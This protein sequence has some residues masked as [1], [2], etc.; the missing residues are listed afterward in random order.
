VAE[1]VRI[2]VEE[3]GVKALQELLEVAVELK[4]SGVLGWLKTLAEN[5]EK[6]IELAA[7]DYPLFRLLALLQAAAGGAAR[8]EPGEFAEARRNTEETIHCLFSGLR[9]ADP[10]KAPKVGML[11]L[12]SALRDPAVQK[13][14]GL[15]LEIAR[16]LGECAEAK[17]KK[18]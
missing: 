11:G 6:I 2:D 18:S 10:A 4:K 16:G 7:S 1:K 9:R 12:T 14:L 17:S 15:L 13:G 8:L 3:E 5:S